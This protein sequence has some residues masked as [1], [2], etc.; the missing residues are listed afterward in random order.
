MSSLIELWYQSCFDH[1][2]VHLQ[3]ECLYHL[4]R[5]YVSRNEVKM[6]RV[7]D[8]LIRNDLISSTHSS[9]HRSAC[10]ILILIIES[11][12]AK[13][14]DTSSVISQVEAKYLLLLVS[15][16]VIRFSLETRSS[17]LMPS[18]FILT[19]ILSLRYS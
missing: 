10:E 4:L 5:L 18:T 14:R 6:F 19:K 1:T 17:L 3:S 8:K 11:K 16:F 2:N 13:A 15:L 9:Y 12:L 7:A